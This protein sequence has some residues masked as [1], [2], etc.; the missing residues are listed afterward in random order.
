M[1]LLNVII[2]LVAIVSLN[3]YCSATDVDVT[4][5]S[6]NIIQVARALDDIGLITGGRNASALAE[7]RKRMYDIPILRYSDHH[8]KTLFIKQ[9]PID[10]ESEEFAPNLEEGVM[11]EET[12]IGRILLRPRPMFRGHSSII[13]YIRGRPDLLIKYQVSCKNYEIHPSL[14]EA[15]YM[16][17]ANERGLAPPILAV[18]PPALL[19]ATKSGKCDFTMSQ[20][21]FDKCL[22]SGGAVRY[23]IMGHVNGQTLFGL[24]SNPGYAV[25]GALQLYTATTIGEGLI[26]TLWGLHSELKIVHGD[27]HQGN[28]MLYE[29]PERGTVKYLTLLDFGRAFHQSHYISQ[30]P[31]RPFGEWRSHMNTQWQ[32]EGYAW[33][34]RDD[35]Y[36]AIQVV[37]QIMN[38][39][40]YY[41][42]E[43]EYE[44]RGSRRLKEWKETA[45][46]FVTDI[47]DPVDLL[48][49][50]IS[51]RNK[52]LIR[53]SF[54]R[55]LNM[56]RSMPINGPL[57][58]AEL[59]KE[60][61]LCT[62]LSQ[63][64]SGLSNS[65]TTT[66]TTISPPSLV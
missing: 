40:P 62:E 16:S 36:K 51:E 8:A 41:E 21:Y 3:V 25:G 12:R 18:S 53:I 45:N 46:W 52:S 56:V 23:T 31:I 14:R 57:P 11:E 6:P 28:V 13:F 48:G 54:E 43:L 32:I 5:M 49:D 55:I 1:S 35:L 42:M 65:T 27:I 61:Q 37:A 60:L 30:Y 33:A 15:W 20:A 39:Y 2:P 34:A 29:D 58:Y 10:K 66:T 17:K 7:F 44:S 26:R 64:R 24:R 22:A 47:F 38:P 9:I 4:T 50:T 59:V 63:P 19:C